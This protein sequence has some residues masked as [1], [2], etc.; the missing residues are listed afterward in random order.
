[1]NRTIWIIVCFSFNQP[2]KWFC[3]SIAGK[4][5]IWKKELF[6]KYHQGR[7]IY[8]S[9]DKLIRVYLTLQE[10]GAFKDRHEEKSHFWHFLWSKWPKKI[11]LFPN[12]YDNASHTLFG[13]QNGLKMGFYGIFVI[14]GM[15]IWIWKCDFLAFLGLKWLK[16]VFKTPN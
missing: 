1:M 15:K 9:H 13:T 10:G 8:I 4:Y 3:S 16:L 12:I 11:W 7:N 2:M 6:N 5:N 14:G